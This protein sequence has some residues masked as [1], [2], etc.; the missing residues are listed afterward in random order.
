MAT[1]VLHP[2]TEQQNTLKRHWLGTG[3]LSQGCSHTPGKH[4]AMSPCTTL[5]QL[6]KTEQNYLDRL[7]HF[8]PKVPMPASAFTQICC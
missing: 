7:I 3:E 2:T 5:L 4:K 6:D 1:S 8:Y